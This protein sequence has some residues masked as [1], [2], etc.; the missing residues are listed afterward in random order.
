MHVL[1]TNLY[2]KY[3][4]GSEN[5]VE[6]LAEG[7]RRAGHLPTVYAPVLGEQADLMRKRGFR[8]V[9][10][11]EQLTETPDIIHAQ[12][13][14]PCLAAMTRFPDVP[15]VYSCHSSFFEV[16]APLPHPQ[17]REVV[18]VDESCAAKCRQRGV[19]SERLSMILNAVDLDRFQRRSALPKKPARALLLTKNHNRRAVVTAACAEMGLEL[20]EFGHGSGRVVP[21]IENRL[22]DYDLVFASARMALE[23]ATAG[24]AVVVCDDRGFAGMLSSRN[25]PAWRPMNFGVGILA[26]PE[27]SENLHRAI[28]QYDAAD[29]A[30]VTDELRRSAGAADYVERYLEVY[31]RAKER[32][33]PGRDEV[34]A[35]TAQWVEEL[36]VTTAER[37]WKAIAGE[38]GLQ[39]SQPEW[40]ETAGQLMNSW[41]ETASLLKASWN[42]T[43]GLQMN[44]LSQLNQA[45]ADINARLDSEAKEKAE[46]QARQHKGLHAMRRLRQ[47]LIPKSFR[48][49]KQ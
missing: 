36:T 12:H 44:S 1:I 42:E 28:A 41:R 19:P 5:V 6:L 43:A 18:A 31:R 26:L 16:E 39:P 23:A 37:K 33:A 32:P 45:V 25:L 11:I 15:V 20:D 22:G 27:T 9:D 17:I 46:Q 38:L 24:C 49:K 34:A 2:V 35:A 47:A 21:D 8:L 14:T 40:S 4:S 29:A 13:L 30:T 3:H 7:L 10:R 48:L